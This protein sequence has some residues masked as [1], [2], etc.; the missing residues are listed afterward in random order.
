M[1]ARLDSICISNPEPQSPRVPVVYFKG[2][3]ARRRLFSRR[4]SGVRGPGLVFIL[5]FIEKLVRV[6][7]AP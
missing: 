2:V 6:T 3:R 4:L 5:P 7:S 1:F